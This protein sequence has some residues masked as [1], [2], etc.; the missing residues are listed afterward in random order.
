MHCAPRSSRRCAL[1]SCRRAPYLAS[2][3]KLCQPITACGMAIGSKS[4]GLWPPILAMRAAPVSRLRA[5]GGEGSVGSDVADAD[6]GGEGS[7]DSDASGVEGA[8][9]DGEGGGDAD[10]SGVDG[11]DS[12]GEAGGGGSCSA[13][14]EGGTGGGGNGSAGSLAFA[15]F[16]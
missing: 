9:S 5:Q 11:A 15:G 3:A 13:V 8:D 16:S 6:S 1:R 2:S 14:D 4:I 7:G 12:R 10:A